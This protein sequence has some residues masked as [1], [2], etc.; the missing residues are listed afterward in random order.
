LNA[1]REDNEITDRICDAGDLLGINV[2]DHI[3]FSEN[4]YA[5]LRKGGYF[6]TK[7]KNT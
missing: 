6:K 3:I 5:S 2:L 7:E 4:G 1:S